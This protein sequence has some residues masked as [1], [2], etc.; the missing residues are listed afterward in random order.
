MSQRYCGGEL[1]VVVDCA[2]L[3]RA[4]R[5]WAGALGY[6]VQVSQHTAYRTLLPP[7]GQ[8]IEVLLQRV[9][10]AKRD[11]N[12]IH[13]DLRTADMDSEIGRIVALGASVLT[14]EPINEDG[15]RWHVLADPDGNEFCILEPTGG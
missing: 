11:K 4:A 7:D 14:R 1:V 3:D 8:G 2:D 13:L 5:F 10:E 12:R 9:P 15:L 6:S